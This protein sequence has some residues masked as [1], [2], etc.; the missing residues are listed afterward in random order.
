MTTTLLTQAF[1]SFGAGMLASLS[2]CVYPMIPVTIGY[3]AHQGAHGRKRRVLLFFL[4]QVLSFTALGI[5]AVSLGEMLGF[6]SES[7]WVNV[8]IG[9][10][11]LGFGLISLVGFFPSRLW[12]WNQKIE[13]WLQQE[14]LSTVSALL[15]GL[16][17][18]LVASPC[19]S[20]IL[21]SVLLTLSQ[22]QT[23]LAGLMLMLSY[24]IGTSSLFLLL[25]LGLIQIKKL[26]RSGAWMQQVHR[27]TS[28]L[29]VLGGAYYIWRGF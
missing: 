23:F 28:T 20:P 4:G 27:L 7:K 2:P 9:G 16:G 8:G 14:S 15:L 26:P 18:A 24:A 5:V 1:S 10:L 21:G 22:G 6:S 25:G 11:M 29:L 3:L 13:G 12:S 19:T 17:S